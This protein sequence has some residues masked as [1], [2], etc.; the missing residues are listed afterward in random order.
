MYLLFVVA[1]AAIK[2]LLCAAAELLASPPEVLKL[3]LAERAL[4]AAR[5]WGLTRLLAI[6]RGVYARVGGLPQKLVRA[7]RS[8]A[9]PIR[10]A[11]RWP[12]A[13][14]IAQ[15]AVWVSAFVK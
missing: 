11:H 13:P 6:V 10:Q 1:G 5:P 9:R 12:I 2:R 14:T 8:L 7:M 4:N 15:L 3:E